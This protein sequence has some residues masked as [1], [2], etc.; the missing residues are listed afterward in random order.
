MSDKLT[1]FRICLCECGWLL[2]AGGYLG[3]VE[4]GP[5]PVT[6]WPQVSVKLDRLPEECGKQAS[7]VPETRSKEHLTEQQR[8]R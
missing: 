8:D 4:T 2:I 5:V 3:R 1:A 6:H 7:V